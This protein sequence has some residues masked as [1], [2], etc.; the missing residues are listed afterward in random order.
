MSDGKGYT[1]RYM[2]YMSYVATIAFVRLMKGLVSGEINP[3]FAKYPSSLTPESLDHLGVGCFMRKS[4]EQEN[5]WEVFAGDNAEYQDNVRKITWHDWHLHASA[6]VHDNFKKRTAL[7]YINSGLPTN[8]SRQISKDEDYL[9][10]AHH[11]GLFLGLEGH[12][13]RFY[14]DD[15]PI[16]TF[17]R[18]VNDFIYKG[19]FDH[20]FDVEARDYV[21]TSIFTD[22]LPRI[23]D[24]TQYLYV[25]K[26]NYSIT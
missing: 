17:N 19:Y 26:V 20:H 9:V 21:E 25:N 6:L 12:F 8:T 14:F 13:Y 22:G 7:F 23:K 18:H 11:L 16:H 10:P 5:V 15:K 24:L 3:I 1:N 2:G 4:P